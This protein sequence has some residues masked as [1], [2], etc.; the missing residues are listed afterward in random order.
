MKKWLLVRVR[1]IARAIALYQIARIDRD[2]EQLRYYRDVGH[3]IH[4]EHLVREKA[5][6][7]R[8]L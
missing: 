8:Q 2:I 7:M 4:L 5:A 6:F 3:R 1:C